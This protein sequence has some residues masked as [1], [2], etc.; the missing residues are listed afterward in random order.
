MGYGVTI[1]E[2]LP[3]VGGML[4]I[5]VPEYRLPKEVLQRDIDYMKGL[6]VEIK[7]NTTIG[8]GSSLDDLASQGYDATFI[9][10]G[11]H[12]GQKV[13]IPGADLN[14]VLV[15]TSFL[16]DINLGKEMKVGSKVVVVGGGHVAVDCARSAWRL[17][18]QE[19]HIACL[20]C[21]EEMPASHA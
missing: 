21:R 4:A 20:E 3:V 15:G 16:R 9:A 14:G 10:T 1:F 17:G 2:A 18:A 13:S 11:A 6:G 8:D 5:G 7:V 19:V 12:R